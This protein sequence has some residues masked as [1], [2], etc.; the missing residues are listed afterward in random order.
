MNPAAP[1]FATGTRVAGAVLLVGYLSGLVPGAIV[2]LVGAIALM[3]FGRA[4]LLDRTGTAV[5]AVALAVAAGGLG[6]AALRWGTLSLREMV[7]AQSVLGPTILVGPE[8]P[9][10]ASIV[11][12][13]AALVAVAA[14]GIEPSGTD[15][16]SRTWAQIEGVLVVAAIAIAFAAPGSGGGLAELFGSPEEPAVT[17]AVV[18]VGA[19]LVAVAPRLLGSR[20]VRWVALVA[21]A[22]AVVVAAS[23]VA[24]SL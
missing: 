4:L 6:V 18:V 16:S 21:S 19:G 22:V 5:A 23:L 15:R 14:W 10:V 20:K 2:S 24:G 9:A 17:A 3:T 11:A 12:L 8:L 13:A 7:G 1:A